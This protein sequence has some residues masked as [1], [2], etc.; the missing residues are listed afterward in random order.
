MP[1]TDSEESKKGIK[2]CKNENGINMLENS[3]EKVV[4]LESTNSMTCFHLRPSKKLDRSIEASVNP[5][6]FINEVT[7]LDGVPKALN[8][9]HEQTFSNKL[10]DRTEQYPKIVFLGTGSCIPNKTRNVSSILVHT[11]YV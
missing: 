10:I 4:S 3:E 9:L 7:Q 8:E 5:E 2:L 11:K 6:E 1:P